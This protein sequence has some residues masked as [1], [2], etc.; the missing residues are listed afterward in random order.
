MHK[1]ERTYT[2]LN[3]RRMDNCFRTWSPCITEILSKPLGA[4]FEKIGVLWRVPIFFETGIQYSLSTDLWRT[5]YWMPN[6]YKLRLNVQALA[7]RS[8]L[9]TY[10]NTAFHTSCFI[11][12]LRDQNA[13]YVK[14]PDIGIFLSA[15]EIPIQTHTCLHH[16]CSVAYN[17]NEH[18]GY[19]SRQR[20]AG[21]RVRLTTSPPSVS[22][23]YR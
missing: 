6:M 12:Q 1:Y 10:R 9:R 14:K 20:A 16:C 13:K 22:R 21:H 2:V 18:Q 19:S 4:V 15:Q 3:T 23:L 17:R 7:R 11:F 8:N 5:N